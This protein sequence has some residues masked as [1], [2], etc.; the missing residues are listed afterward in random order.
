MC[1]RR[2]IEREHPE[3]CNYGD[4]PFKMVKQIAEQLP[5]DILV[6]FHWN[7]EPLLYPRLGDALRLFSDNIRQLDTNGKLLVKK[8]DEIIDNLD[9]ITISVF[10]GDDEAEEQGLIAMAFLDI[11]EERRPRIVYRLLGEVSPYYVLFW[12]DMPGIVVTRTLHK[13]MGSFGYEKPVTIPETGI[14]LEILNHLAIDRFGNV[15]PCV[16]FDPYG[17]NILGNLKDLSLEEI[18]NGKKRKDWMQ[19]HIDGK[20]NE[21]PLCKAC[22]YWG[23]PI[24]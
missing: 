23:V 20:R 10:Q 6:Q 11:K 18:W 24:G 16:R 22:D 14:C 2:K 8:A 15:S 1:G 17:L 12:K 9:V 5:S 21:V 4:M 19:K 7:G 13:A 3:F